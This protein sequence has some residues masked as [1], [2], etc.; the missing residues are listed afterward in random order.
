MSV[1][2]GEQTKLLDV[3]AICAVAVREIKTQL[4]SGV[5]WDGIRAVVEFLTEECYLCYRLV[6]LKRVMERVFL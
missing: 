2:L 5:V 4:S 1:V 3:F 6:C